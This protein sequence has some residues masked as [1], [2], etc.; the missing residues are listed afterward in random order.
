MAG[1]R[2][3]S[4]SL[5]Q[6]S[7]TSGTVDMNT[8]F[9]AQ[10]PTRIDLAGGWTDLIPFAMETDGFVLNAAIDLYASA[11]LTPQTGKVVSFQSADAQQ[12]FCLQSAPSETVNGLSLPEAIIL[13]VRQRNGYSLALDSRAPKGGGLGGSGAIGVVLVS[14]LH[15]FAGKELKSHQIVDIA[16][17][18]ERETGIP[19]GK[20][21]HYA[22]VFGGLN[23]LRCH[24]ESVVV[25]RLNLNSEAVQRLQE[26]LLL[27]YTGE[28]HFSGEILQN[29]VDA[30]KSG[31]RRTREALS[32]LRR[33]AQEMKAALCQADLSCFGYLLSENWR[34]QKQLHPSVT[35][36]RVEHLFEIAERN[37]SIGGKAC[38]AGG[39]GCL[40]FYCPQDR[41]N[42]VTETLLAVGARS[43]RFSFDFKGLLVQSYEGG[44]LSF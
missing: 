28:S 15:T 5:I 3:Q 31:N 35:S 10:A 17:Q 39:G 18:I 43:I 44:T 19:C 23:F 34:Y 8:R 12:Q 25:T 16:N 36:K 32:A 26:S 29:V 21:D 13:T 22:S 33:I 37:G 6:D 20:Q 4:G 2:N 38:G 24:G 30:Y 41:Q 7:F 42:S 9:Y 27:V 40:V 14:L 11:T 1:E